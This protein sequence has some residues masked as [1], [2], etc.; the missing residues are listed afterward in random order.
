M[1]HLYII[2]LILPLI[3]FGQGWETTFGE[4]EYGHVGSS[5]QQTEDGGYIISG[6]AQNKVYFLNKKGM[7]TRTI[8]LDK[9]DTTCR[10]QRFFKDIYTE[11]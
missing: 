8:N 11:F 4:G 2:L 5:V 6:S 7:V 1:K 3:G 9:H 10:V